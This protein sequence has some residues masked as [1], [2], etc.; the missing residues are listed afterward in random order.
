VKLVG[1]MSGTSMDG[2][3]AALLDVR[4]EGD[5]LPRCSLLRFHSVPYDS[6]RRSRVRAVVDGGDADAVCRLHADL[7]EWLAEAVEVLLEGAG[8][9]RDQVEAVGSHGHTV[10][11]RPPDHQGRGTT[12]QLGDPATLAARTG[13]PVVSD[14]RAADMA[15]GGHG[16]PLVPW[17]DRVLFSRPGRS[18]ALQ[19]I[20]G[21]GNVTWLPPQGSAEPPVAFDTGPGNVLLDI[22]AEA[23]TAG[24]LR[25]DEEGRLAGRGTVDEDTVASL[26][27]SAFFREA[28]PRSTG[29]ELFGPEV[30]EGLS[31]D[32]GLEP[33]TEDA[34][35]ADL[36]AT[37]TRFT[38]RSVGDALRR[39][40]VP[41][42]LD[43]VVLT[44]GGA[45]NPTLVRH[46]R[47]ELADLGDTAE[48]PLPVS[49]GAEAL[50]MDPDA[51]E[52]AAFA[53][54]AWA[55]LR[56]I[57][58]NIPSVTGASG[59]RVLGSFTPAPGRSRGSPP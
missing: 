30:V 28:P 8:V 25:C 3:D 43:E 24:R 46:I 14:F 53:L 48:S 5:A 33:G 23:A 17:P 21:I 16:A 57:P 22:A 4:E 41:L 7:A 56:G 50:G 18:R 20:G 54:L 47:E 31:R 13:I 27:A 42:G 36:L 45:S 51:R 58:G 38:A 37:L 2:I 11:H 6:P 34:G 39:W 35:W 29:R 19:N 26:M 40:V 59:P 52:A 55:H 49:V 12:L 44:G 9:A 1:L 32:R 15:A 10:R